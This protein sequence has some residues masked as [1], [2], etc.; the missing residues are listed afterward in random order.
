MSTTTIDMSGNYLEWARRN[1][2][3]NNFNGVYEHR[4]IRADCLEWLEKNVRRQKYG[5]VFLDPPTFSTSKRMNRSFDVQRDHVALIRRTMELLESEG[6][7]V[8]SN[9]LRTFRL[10]S[11]ALADLYVEDI[12]R[13]TLPPDFKRNPRIHNCWK[14]S[15]KAGS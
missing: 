13:Q 5:L 11:G 14:I 7:L 1:M 4:F 8:F 12:S 10:D 6:I 2:T 15:R 9:N 3:L